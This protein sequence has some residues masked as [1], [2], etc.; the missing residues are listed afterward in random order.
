MNNY[1]QIEYTCP[2]SFKLKSGIPNTFK[3]KQND[4]F[5]EVTYKIIAELED[6]AEQ[7]M[8]IKSM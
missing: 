8:V 5:A 2:F 6:N 3:Y 7:G 1:Q 4:F